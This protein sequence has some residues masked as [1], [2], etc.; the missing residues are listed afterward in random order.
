VF[1]P[2]S[3]MPIIICLHCHN[4]LGRRGAPTVTDW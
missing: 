1:E 2:T 3:M 4:R